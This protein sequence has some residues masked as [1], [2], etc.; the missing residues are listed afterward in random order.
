MVWFYF[1]AWKLSEKWPVKNGDNGRKKE[2]LKILSSAKEI[3]QL[4]KCINFVHYKTHFNRRVCKLWVT[5]RGVILQRKLRREV[6][7]LKNVFWDKVPVLSSKWHT[8]SIEYAR[9]G[10][11]TVA[12][13][14]PVQKVACS[15]HVRVKLRIFVRFWIINGYTHRR[16]LL[17]QV[18]SYFK[19]TLGRR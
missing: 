13:L 12:R 19:N 3:R 6:H 4:R 10:G 14:T 2:F 1:V 5:A 18:S 15:N 9:P 17:V 7:I 11:A 8:L 16:P